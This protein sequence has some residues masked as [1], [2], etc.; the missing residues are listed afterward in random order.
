M[1]LSPVDVRVLASLIEKEATTP[2][3]YP[4]TLGALR[5]ACNQATNRRPV[6][7]YD[8]RTVE[9]SLEAL[10]SGGLVRFVFPSHGARTV[11]YRHTAGE[12]FELSPGELL[13]LS[14]LALRGP[15]TVA[16]VRARIERLVPA[17]EDPSV[18]A[19]L[20]RLAARDPEPLAA[21]LERRPG[22]SANRWASLLAGPVDAANVDAADVEAIAPDDRAPGA[23]PSVAGPSVAGPSVVELVE[24][25]EQLGAV[26]EALAARLE[27][28]E[29]ELGL[30]PA[31][32]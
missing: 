14:A 30:G 23:G 8:E 22:E 10:K 27:R 1:I 25:V 18:E 9:A 20:D 11:R 13:A 28:L 2:D 26:V 31:A 19:M 32:G 24:R 15:Q 17:D 12:R 3:N 5:L 21:R 29:G 16:E 4:L 6:V 7:A